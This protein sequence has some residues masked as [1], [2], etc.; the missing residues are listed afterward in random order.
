MSE[1]TSTFLTRENITL[2]LSIFGSIGTLI[3]FI[4]SYLTKRKN[5]KIHIVSSTYK[6]NLQRLV[7]IITFENR[8]RLPIS[9]TSTSAII[10]GNEYEL[11]QHPHCVGEY[12]HKHGNNVVDRKFEYN[13]RFP[14]DI[15][16]LSAISG[17]LLFDVVPKELENLSTPLILQ[18]H[19]TRGLVQKIELQPNQIKWI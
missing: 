1:L 5:L 10:N 9:V 3:T 16:Q 15:Q 7:L 13:L 18:V 17:Y 2:A 4:S 6:Q 8:S 19:S 14:S 11:L 12:T